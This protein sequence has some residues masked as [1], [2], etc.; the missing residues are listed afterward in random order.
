MNV[1]DMFKPYSPEIRGDLEMYLKEHDGSSADNKFSGPEYFFVIRDKG[2][3]APGRTWLR[4]DRSP[5]PDFCYF[6]NTN[7]ILESKGVGE[8]NMSAIGA[9][10]GIYDPRKVLRRAVW[11]ISGLNIPIGRV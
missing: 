3:M 10:K 1:Y 4:V 6:V 8:M 5:A 11:S 2:W 7:F 9:K